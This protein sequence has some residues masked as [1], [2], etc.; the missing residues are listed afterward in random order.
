M[1]GEVALLLAYLGFWLL[2]F[3]LVVALA[4]RQHRSRLELDE[5]ERRVHALESVSRE[6]ETNS[7][8]SRSGAG[9]KP[10]PTPSVHSP[11]RAGHGAGPI[12]KS[13]ERAGPGAGPIEKSDSAPE[14][15]PPPS[16][17]EPIALEE[18]PT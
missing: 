2:S 12:E 9:L 5:L 13:P 4:R 3:A 17:R 1:S 14:S 18:H 8:R 6:K 16:E 15:T 11:E 7:Q 10:A